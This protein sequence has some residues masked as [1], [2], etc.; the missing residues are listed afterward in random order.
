MSLK[1]KKKKFG[2]RYGKCHFF[3]DSLKFQNLEIQNNHCDK[4]KKK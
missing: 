2:E 4:L 3:C 1:M